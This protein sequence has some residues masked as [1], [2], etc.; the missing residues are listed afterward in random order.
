MCLCAVEQVAIFVKNNMLGP[1]R[2]IY[3][4]NFVVFTQ[5]THT[6]N[7]SLLLCERGS[8]GVPHCRSYRSIVCACRY[9][10]Y[11][12]WISALLALMSVITLTQ[13][14]VFNQAYVVCWASAV[15][16]AFLIF[17]ST[18][19]RQ[20]EIMFITGAYG[21]QKSSFTASTFVLSKSR[22]NA[23]QNIFTSVD[24]KFKFV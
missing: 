18:I 8:V 16:L 3:I 22:Q 9:F 20:I 14:F 24:H 4:T 12:E 13:V 10:I 15:L 2:C 6:T 7:Y 1:V 21:L 23:F 19:N 5:P 17:F 11:C